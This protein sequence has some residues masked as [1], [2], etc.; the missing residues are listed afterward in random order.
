MSRDCPCKGLRPSYRKK[1]KF[2]PNPGLQVR[3]ALGWRKAVSIPEP[4]TP[5]PRSFKWDTLRE[6]VRAG[7]LERK[8]GGDC[9]GQSSSSGAEVCM[10]LRGY[11]IAARIVVHTCTVRRTV[12]VLC[13][14]YNIVPAATRIQMNRGSQRASSKIVVIQYHSVR[15]SVPDTFLVMLLFVPGLTCAGVVLLLVLLGSSNAGVL[16]IV[17]DHTGY[18]QNP[19][20][21]ALMKVLHCRNSYI[22]P[23]P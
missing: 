12:T 3:I 20:T 1:L 10:V 22:P 4:T 9:S 17:R 18:G 19:S 8:W 13:S 14:L 23:V 7:R 5:C 11:P 16:G 2:R 21:V 6:E 15:M